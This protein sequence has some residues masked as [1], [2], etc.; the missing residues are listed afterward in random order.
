MK[1]FT[2]ICLLNSFAN[3]GKY[4]KFSEDLNVFITLKIEIF[5]TFLVRYWFPNDAH[6]KGSWLERYIVQT[7]YLTELIKMYLSDM[8]PLLEHTNCPMLMDQI[9]SHQ[10][11]ADDL[12][13]LALY[14]TT[15]QK[16]LDTLAK[17]S[18]TYCVITK[19]E[20]V[21]E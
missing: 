2:E 13:L 9:I 8:S 15:L 1:V 19:G 17:G 21:S 6:R 12:I 18:F 4:V 20:G 7:C 11:W 14:P 16:Q 3:L 10:L 5:S